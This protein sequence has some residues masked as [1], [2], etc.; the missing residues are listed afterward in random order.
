MIW[1][2]G[3][4]NAG[5]AFQYR[6]LFPTM[7]KNWREE[8]G[9]GNVPFYWA[10]LANFMATKDNPEGSAW[11]ELRE[12]QSLTRGL[13]NSGQAVIIDIGET[14]DIHPR[15]KRDVGIRLGLL[16][17]NNDYG[18]TQPCESPQLKSASFEDEKATLTFDFVYEG[19]VSRGAAPTGFAVAGEDKVFHWAT[20]EIVGKDTIVVRSPKVARPVAVRYGWA[21]NPVVTMY[22]S[23]KLPMNPFRTDDWTGVTVNNR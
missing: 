7:I 10:Q 15:N 6:S 11:A 21:D 22:N 3:E 18:K 12:A 23:A 16:A 13:P 17:L 8:W 19:L 1:Y 9:Q 5:R 14:D 20:A 4:S 2:Q